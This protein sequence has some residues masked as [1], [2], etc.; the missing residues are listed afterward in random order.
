[1]AEEAPD[2]SPKPSGGCLK[3]PSIAAAVIVCVICITLLRSCDRLQRMVETVFAKGS[4]ED[5]T[6]VFRENLIKVTATQ[7]DILELA[8]LDMDETLTRYNTKS[9]AWNLINIGTTVSEIRVPAVYRYHLKLGDPWQVRVNNGTCVV[10]APVIRPSLPPAIRTEKMEKKNA[11]GWARFNAEQNMAALEKSMTPS[12]EGRAGHSSHIDKVRDP[13]RKATAEFVKKWVLSKDSTSA[14]DV[15]RIIIV[16]AD[17]P[18]A[19]NLDKL[20]S[21][22]ATLTISP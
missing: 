3:W 9:I 11:A 4:K 18:D 13:A 10:M 5:V 21:A 12:L 20:A 8:T 15:K 19:K 14:A 22:P 2:S 17:E 6:Q 16:F 7:G 1:M